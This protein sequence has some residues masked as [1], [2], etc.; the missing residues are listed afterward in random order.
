MARRLCLLQPARSWELLCTCVVVRTVG[1][2]DDPVS[3]SPMSGKD[4]HR[5][6]AAALISL[7][8]K[9]VNAE[10]AAELLELAA[11]QIELAENETIPQQQQQKQNWT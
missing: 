8:D 10:E 1:T 4:V 2:L 9:I 6:R 3:S 5:R 11:E 7:A